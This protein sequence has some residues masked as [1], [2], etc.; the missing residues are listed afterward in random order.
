MPTYT[1]KGI[2]TEAS[3]AT[4]E[5]IGTNYDYLEIAEEGGRVYR[6][7]RAFASSLSSSAQA[8][9]PVVTARR[10]LLDAPPSLSMTIQ[11]LSTLL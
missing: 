5:R 11:E 3:I 6:L 8:D 7:Y 1:L 9:D 2:E 4:L 10:R